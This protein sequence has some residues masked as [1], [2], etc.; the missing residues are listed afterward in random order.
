MQG[1]LLEVITRAVEIECCRTRFPRASWWTSSE[2][3]IGQSKRASDVA[4]SGS[5]K[6]VSAP[7]TVIAHVVALRAEEVAPAE[8]R[9]AE[10]AAGCRRTR[11]HQEGQEGR[12]SRRRRGQGQEEV[13]RHVPGGG[14]R[15]S[16]R[17]VCTYAA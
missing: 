3:M 6:L 16:G 5:M 15:Q 7:E 4:L 17:G 14:S 8:A 11:S 2:L 1:G 13:A 9:R 12:R 10:A